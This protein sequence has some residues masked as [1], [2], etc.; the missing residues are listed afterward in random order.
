MSYSGLRRMTTGI[1]DERTTTMEHSSEREL[2]LR[3]RCAGWPDCRIYGHL[4]GALL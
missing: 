2:Q 3:L 4:A 1:N